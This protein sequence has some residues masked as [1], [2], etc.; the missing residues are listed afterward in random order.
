[1]DLSKELTS[2]F[3]LDQI[4]SLVVNTVTKNMHIA[5]GSIILWDDVSQK[6]KIKIARGLDYD[7]VSNTEFSR[8]NCFIQWLG[9]SNLVFFREEMERTYNEKNASN[10]SDQQWR[11][12]GRTLATLRALNINLSIPIILGGKLIGIF[13]LSEKKSEQM[14]SPEDIGLLSTIANQAAIAI[15]NARLY[16]EMRDM[17]K[18]LYQ[19]DKM[20]SLGTLA[21]S[22]AHEVGNPLTTLKTYLQMFEEKKDDKEFISRAQEKMT[23]EV[24]RLQDIIDQLRSYSR[25]SRSGEVNDINIIEVLED[26]LELVNY[27]LTRV[28]VRIEKSYGPNI[29]DIQANASHLK[30]IFM[31]L[32]LNACQAMAEGGQI[33]VSVEYHQS[34]R[35]MDFVSGEH[36]QIAFQDTGKGIPPELLQG[37]KLFKPFFTT[38]EKGTGLGLSITKKLI[39]EH[40]GEIK[41]NSQ[42]D[43]GTT[44]TIKLPLKQE[45]EQVIG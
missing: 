38:K 37:G 45:Q 14:F 5:A 9:N 20:V 33:K 25:V 43:A 6:F 13:N 12:I 10:L 31:N 3:N 36:I 21:S 8:E 4:L 11:E 15:E 24:E 28:N 39:E 44:F 30:Q 40:G 7:L 17:E 27:Q 2:L 29:P 22:V 35:E 16:T 42:I 32:I 19:A 1:R 41:V 23:G 18:S 26:V 34:G